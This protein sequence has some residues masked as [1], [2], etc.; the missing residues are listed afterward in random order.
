MTTDSSTVF[1]AYSSYYDLLYKDKDYQEETKYICAVLA[2]H[3]IANGQILEFGSGT[4]RHGRLLAELNYVVHGIELSTEMIARAESSQRFHCEAGDIR[5]IH[6]DRTYD[7]VLAIF[8]VISYQTRNSDV[9]AVF[10]RAHEHLREGGLF[11][12]DFWYSPAVSSQRP[13]VRIKRMSD[14]TT[15]LTR[16]AEPTIYPNENRV[17]VNYTIIAHNRTT[18]VFTKIE[19]S[20]PM[21]HFSLPEIDLLA[22][23]H[24]FRRIAAEEFLSCREP[25][26]DTWGVCV[27]LKKCSP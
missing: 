23:I 21:R 26:E 17:D 13:S 27:V 6:L 3:G 11:I 5:T 20:H 25:S 14:T 9:Q 1:D 16:I 18:D 15:E 8:H 4:G 2:K 12:F 24:G 7:A 10:M 22:S 19:E